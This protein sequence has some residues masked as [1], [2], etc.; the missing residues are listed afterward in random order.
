MKFRIT[1]LF[2]LMIFPL[3]IQAQCVSCTTTI[4]GGSGGANANS[5]DVICITGNYTGSININGSNVRICIAST[6][7]WT[8]NNFNLNN[9]PT[10][11][12]H[13]TLTLSSNISS[14]ASINVKDGGNCNLTRSSGTSLQ[15][16]VNIT[17][18]DGGTLDVSSRLNMLGN[19]TMLH[20][21]Q[22]GV[23][24][25]NTG[26]PANSIGFENNDSGG[27]DIDGELT[28]VNQFY[29]HG[30]ATIGSTGVVNITGDLRT[31]F[32]G[33]GTSLDNNGTINSI[34]GD[35]DGSMA[36]TGNYIFTGD[37]EIKSSGL[38]NSGYW[39][40]DGNSEFTDGDCSGQITTSV[41]FW[42]NSSSN[43]GDFDSGC[44]AGAQG[45]TVSK[46]ALPVNLISFKARKINSTQVQLLWTTADEEN[47]SHYELEKSLDGIEFKN[48]QNI[49][50]IE[51]NS[52]IK[53]YGSKNFQIQ[54]TTQY[55]R[56]KMVDLDG[57]F[58]Y[59]PIV[60]VDG[61]NA[62]IQVFPN[63]T[64]N[65]KFTLLMDNTTPVI[66]NIYNIAGQLQKRII[67]NGSTQ[68]EISLPEGGNEKMYILE[69]ISGTEVQN[70]K[71]F[72]K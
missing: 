12:I 31:T 19:T 23:A 41:T 26:T 49:P 17:V 7:S 33:A 63:P 39:E 54:Q 67:E 60:S 5:N 20:V 70:V 42:D 30:E 59:S 40:V 44:S 55:F 35:I 64:H 56:L 34:N 24:N 52:N 10:I 51:E 50:T 47:F 46:L 28:I 36:G 8:P 11:D 27:I 37:L 22:G 18:E 4:T 48:V 13:G 68:Y 45:Y 32:K 25:V 29:N 57:S 38:L 15:N 71:L 69:F 21:N 16:G 14:V 58:E 65:K 43:G 72:V 61:E 3:L 2:A 9:N 62:S 1:T 53:N 6:G 66:I